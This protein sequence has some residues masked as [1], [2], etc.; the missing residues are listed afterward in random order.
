MVI[1][2]R[3]LTL[4]SPMNRAKIDLRSR[5]ELRRTWIPGLA[6]LSFAA[7]LASMLIA[8]TTAPGAFNS[9]AQNEPATPTPTPT[10]TADGPTGQ[11]C[12]SNPP[13]TVDI[14]TSDGHIRAT[15]N[16]TPA[17]C[18]IEELDYARPLIAQHAWF[19]GS[20]LDDGETSYTAIIDD[21]VTVDGLY[22]FYV[23]LRYNRR[24]LGL[25]TYSTPVVW[26]HLSPSMIS[27][28]TPTPTPTSTSTPTP[29]ATANPVAAPTATPTPTPSGPPAVPD[30]PTGYLTPDGSIV[31]DWDDV[32]G[33]QSYQLQ[34]W[35]DEQ[36]AQLPVGAIA[37]RFSGSSANI[38]GLPN[39]SN[40]FLRVRTVNY[41]G[42]S[43]WSSW[44]ILANIPANVATP[45]PTATPTASPTATPT[46][47]ATSTPTSTATATPTNTPLPSS[48]SIVTPTSAC[49]LP[50]PTQPAGGASG[51]SPR[52]YPK[53]RGLAED[54]V[55]A[56]EE[57]R[58]RGAAGSNGEETMFVV[59]RLHGL[60]S[61][62]VTAFLAENGVVADQW[63]VERIYVQAYVPIR[64]LG[65]LSELPEVMNIDHV[66]LGV[67]QA[68][69]GSSP[70]GDDSAAAGSSASSSPTPTP[71]ALF[72][73]GANNWHD[74]V[75]PIKGGGV[76][77][78]VIDV[79]FKGFTEFKQKKQ[80]EGLLTTFDFWCST[81][82]AADRIGNCVATNI[83]EK[84]ATHGTAVVEALMNI[85]P[86]IDLYIARPLGRT[87][88]Y[89][90]V[91]WMVEQ[92][93]VDVISYS[94][95]QRF[96]G[97]GDGTTW[98][99]D[100]ASFLTQTPIP[101]WVY[102]PLHTVNLAVDGGAVWVSAAGNRGDRM[103]Y[104]GD[105]TDENRD[106][107][108]DDNDRWMDFIVPTPTPD[109][110]NPNVA[111]PTPVDANS[112]LV[113]ESKSV[114][115][116]LRWENDSDGDAADLDL[117]LCKD[118]DCSHGNDIKRSS[119]PQGL[120]MRPIDHLTVMDS[121]VMN[122]NYQGL[123]RAYLRICHQSGDQ[124][125]SV[126]LRVYDHRTAKY[127]S[128]SQ[129]FYSIG[130][131][132]ES[133][134]PGALAVG[135]VTATTTS[136]NPSNPAYF[137]EDYSSRGPALD[138]R[139]KPEIVGV[140][141]EYSSVDIRGFFDGTSA[142]APHVAGLAALVIQRFPDYTP[143]QV[144]QYL[145]THAVKQPPE[146]GDPRFSPTPHTTPTVNNSWGW[147]FAKLPTLTST[148]SA[149]PTPTPTPTSTAAATP[150][151]TSTG[152]A[153]PTAT[154][155]A[156]PTPTPTATATPTATSTPSPT[157]TSTPSPTPTPTPTATPSVT[158]ILTLSRSTIYEG[159]AFDVTASVNPST[160]EIRF[161]ISAN[162]GLSQCFAGAAGQAD[163]FTDPMSA[164]TTLTLHACPSGQAT[165]RLLRASDN[166]EIT[167][168][169]FTISARPALS[170]NLSV[171]GVTFGESYTLRI[172]VGDSF[173]MRASNTSPSHTFVKFRITSPL[174]AVAC[175][176]GTSGQDGASGQTGSPTQG[177]L[178]PT[179]RTI[180]GCSA[181]QGTV[182]LLASYDDTVIATLNVKVV[183]P[184]PTNLQF[185]A[186]TSWMNFYWDA[187]EG[188][189][190]FQYSFDGG[191][192]VEVTATN[193][194]ISGLVIGSAH[195]FSVRTYENAVSSDSVSI[196]GETTCGFA[197]TACSTAGDGILLHQFADGIHRVHAKLAPGTYTIG[198]PEDPSSCEWERLGN[199]QNADDQVLESGTWTEGRQV[200]I[201]S[202]DVAFYTFGCGTWTLQSP[203]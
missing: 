70:I 17:T 115:F 11:T 152:T 141:R 182:K 34:L 154:A 104:F 23:N 91:D 103:T 57:A 65:P 199:L 45:T 92:K 130:S 97:P 22:A 36:W 19:V 76:K 126:Q 106:K 132:G 190:T 142:A 9:S 110:S 181:G 66:E 145:K 133:N 155:T 85:A 55:R 83:E 56:Y 203:Q 177:E 33:S 171:S 162:L 183:P 6:L 43:E 1:Y 15:W 178:A 37:A 166:A 61:H 118:E 7:L 129:S 136:V 78:G 63:F 173:T 41:A 40:Y 123:G 114:S 74:A 165:I 48:G 86:E 24:I 192:D 21:Y 167:S 107:W 179:S 60:F 137:I 121:G 20:R 27:T 2:C 68:A 54:A 100:P 12:L 77:V 29:T 46:P 150:T 201:A 120:E 158:G 102:S 168:K 175:S 119:S 99:P 174:G 140:T 144:V 117:Y 128:W 197:G 64:L 116:D 53:L 10:P 157:P 149:T 71:A 3:I 153:T 69:Y 135:A 101:D 187:P 109:A 188:Y 111:T 25:Q 51:P 164:T 185:N 124:P 195:R 108:D 72:R 90:A 50:A 193:K 30:A 172:Q 84:Y 96:D 14:D 94:V 4:L 5:S 156:T 75:T 161:R 49:L 186:G 194:L 151:P 18:Y 160:T 105:Y 131:P 44:L 148:P 59:I 62:V 31:L 26:V 73:H 67:P 200:T 127:M 184:P 16:W 180:Y 202:S 93:R 146:P 58:A 47:T 196:S 113:H 82:R 89:E 80:A 176:A 52:V 125:D 163:T 147:G 38:T 170:A 13:L 42:T 139:T 35:H 8:S 198:T 138:G 143:A 87:Q 28:A 39:Y 88:L 112:I 95:S 169:T 159:E 98:L 191:S 32:P 79:S 189:D 81:D 134:R 122:T